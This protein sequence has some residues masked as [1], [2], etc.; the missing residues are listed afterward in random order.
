MRHFLIPF[1]VLSASVAP[2]PATAQD[3]DAQVLY[4]QNCLKCHGSEIYTRADRKID[5]LDALRA[6]VRMCEQNLDLTWFDDQV[7][8]V[9]DLLNRNYYK[10]DQ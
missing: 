3:D 5:S 1:I 2:L 9:A 8:G 6:Q 10:F 4:E 7:D